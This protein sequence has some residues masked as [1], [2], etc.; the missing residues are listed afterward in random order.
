MAAIKSSHAVISEAHEVASHEKTTAPPPTSS[1]P[2]SVCIEQVLAMAKGDGEASYSKNSEYEAEL[3][4]RTLLA[5]DEALDAVNLSSKHSGP[6]VVAD[7]GSSSGPNT[8]ASVCH[9]VNKLRL[10]LPGDTEFQAFF[11][12]LPSNDFNNLF[13]LLGD[14]STGPN[15]FAAGVP[16]SFYGRLFPSSSVTV[17]FS[18]LCLQ[19]MSKVCHPE[20]KRYICHPRRA[21]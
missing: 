20:K 6:V 21:F 11:D 8:I 5:L 1:L 16:G 18:S 17:F 4:R 7:L 14:S 2:S 19:W 10:R 3:S 15:F 13:R 12:D 9:I